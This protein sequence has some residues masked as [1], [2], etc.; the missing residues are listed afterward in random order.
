MGEVQSRLATAAAAA[1]GGP[2]KAPPL[3]PPSTKLTPHQL[4]ALH[5]LRLLVAGRSVS[6]SQPHT[7]SRLGFASVV[8]RTASESSIG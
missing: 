4:R 5:V 6:T 8:A 7:P 1:A 3:L 2:A